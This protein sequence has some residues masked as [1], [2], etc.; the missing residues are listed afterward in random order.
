MQ[1]S[2]VLFATL[3]DLVKG[4]L[5]GTLHKLNIANTQS[6][7]GQTNEALLK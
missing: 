1:D 7:P 3:F 6:D 4:T 2:A 5:R